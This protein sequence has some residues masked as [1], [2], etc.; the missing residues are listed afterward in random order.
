MEYD[1]FM[2][3]RVPRKWV[4]FVFKVFD[5]FKRFIVI[6]FFSIFDVASFDRT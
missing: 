3:S 4:E 6:F 2:E 1:N 5:L